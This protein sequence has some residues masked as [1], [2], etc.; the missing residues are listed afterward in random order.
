MTNYLKILW[1]IVIKNFKGGFCMKYEI[2]CETLA[3]I[4]ISNGK[5][6]I[7][8]ENDEF[9]IG[10]KGSNIINDSCKYFGSSYEGRIKG[11][12]DLLGSSHKL[13]IIIEE[14]NKIVF[15]PTSSPRNEGCI[16]LALNSIDNYERVNKENTIL[17]FTCGKTIE[18][19]IPYQIVDNQILRATRLEALYEKRV[20]KLKK[21]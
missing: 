13:P 1:I 7:I 11:S 21:I 5:S 2:N 20:K 18:I 14:I 10:K 4:P 12:K 3:I 9:I 15:F 6:K 16:W 17:K 19:E 8:E